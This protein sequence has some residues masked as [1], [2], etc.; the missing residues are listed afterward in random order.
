MINV[1]AKQVFARARPE[2]WLPVVPEATFSFPSGH[3]M[4]SMATATALVVLLWPTVWR[5]PAIVLGMLFVLGVGISRIY[6]GAHFPSDVAAGWA[7]SLAWVLGI[8][9][10]RADHRTS[11]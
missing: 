9:A 10:L 11:V 5:W 4:A 1:A 8:Q 7:A 6:L 3:A 2:P